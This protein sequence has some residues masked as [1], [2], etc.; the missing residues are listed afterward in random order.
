LEGILDGPSVEVRGGILFGPGA[1]TGSGGLVNGGEVAPGI[2]LGTLTVAS[3]FA[4]YTQTAAGTLTVQLNGPA[5]GTGYDVLAVN[6]I[7]RLAGALAGSAGFMPSVGQVFR[8]IDNDSTD[9]V[10]GTF[11]GLPEGAEV[12]LSGTRFR[13]SYA[14]GTGNDVTLTVTGFANAPPTASAGGPYTIAEEDSLTLDASA[15][16]DPDGDPL[17]YAWDV[18][19]DG[20]FGDAVGP[21]PILT[22]AQLDALGI[23][24]GPATRTMTV[25]VADPTH[26]AVAATAALTVTN[27][28]PTAGVA[29]PVDAVRGQVRT[30]SLSAA[31]VAADLAVGFAY[32]VD[33]GDGTPVES[34]PA[35]PGNGAGLAVTHAYSAEG[36]YTA[37][38]TA[39]DKDAGTSA[40][41]TTS[42]VVTRV[43]LQDD[44]LHPGQLALVVGGSPGN[45][46]IRVSAGRAA[47]DVVVRMNRRNEGTFHPT[48][49]IIVAGYD[50]DD[51]VGVLAQV[52]LPCWLDGGAGNDRLIGGSGPNVVRGGEGN[53]VVRGRDG[54][55]VLIGGAGADTVRGGRGDDLL[56]GGATAFDADD[57]ALAGVQAEW[58]SARTYASRLA[59]VWGDATNPEYGLRLNGATFL[60]ADGPA[61]TV[62]DDAARDALYGSNGLDAMFANTDAGVLDLAFRPDRGEAVVDV[63]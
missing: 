45:D 7:V 39:T 2:G 19:G 6:G 34:I 59:N 30:F 44:P 15:S 13:I 57:V 17:T 24:D 26:P 3:T 61:P 35:T 46:T 32:A 62:G 18:N 31:D 8:I 58:L 14:G 48:S 28:A 54:R 5:A 20:V 50:G 29:G 55:D 43:A 53:D 47:G 41:A 21:T 27:R 11:A 38:L 23:A 12:T 9:P 16:V 22:W 4:G 10:V 1:V 51:V 49:R 52:T 63:D 56:V 60:V 36:T 40:A 37:R 33:W 42:T 25:R